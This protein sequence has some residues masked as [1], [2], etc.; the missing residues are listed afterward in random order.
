[1]YFVS[2]KRVISTLQVGIGKCHS[3]YIFF[4]YH[5]ILADSPNIFT[6]NLS[7]IFLNTK[8]ICNVFLDR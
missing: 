1:M 7:Q 3:K 5:I 4:Y 2:G 6:T 8:L